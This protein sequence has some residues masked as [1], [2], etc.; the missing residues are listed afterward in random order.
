MI[1]EFTTSTGDI[2][3]IRILFKGSRYGR[4]NS[5]TWDHE[6][7]G[8]EFW[9][10]VGPDHQN[11]FRETD[12]FQFVSRYYAKTLLTSNL[13]A[14]RGI[15]LQGDV[16]AWKI[17]W[18][19]LRPM[20]S[21]VR[22]VTPSVGDGATLVV[23]SDR[24]PYTVVEVK[25]QKRIVVQEDDAEWVGPRRMPTESQTYQYTPNPENPK[26]EISLRK[27]GSW[28]RVGQRGSGSYFMVG[29][30]RKYLDPSF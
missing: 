7:H 30:R 22:A 25:T 1:K 20:L 11:D 23:G 3:R 14:A 18:Y 8:V 2:Y 24:Y 17:D 4:G 12:G 16:P 29:S 9:W 10:F 6:R 15:D 19:D 27:G 28:C 13:K 26:V 5:L 21:W